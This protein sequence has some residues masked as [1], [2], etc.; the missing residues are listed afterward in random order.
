[1]KGL[2]VLAGIVS[3]CYSLGIVPEVGSDID[4]IGLVRD[5]DN[6][7]GSGVLIT[8]RCVLTARHVPG[9]RFHLPGGEV[10]TGVR[11]NHPR[12]D[13]AIINFDVDFPH[14]VEPLYENNLNRNVTLAGFGLTGRR[15]DDNSGFNLTANTFGTLRQGVNRLGRREDVTIQGM[16][17]LGLQFDLDSGRAQDPPARRDRLGDGDA[18]DG[19]AGITPGDSGGAA[20]IRQN[21]RWRLVGISSFQVDENNNYNPADPRNPTIAELNNLLDFG[22]T[23]WVVDIGGVLRVPD[24]VNPILD[25]YGAWIREN[26]AVPEPGSLAAL[27]LGLSALVARRQRRS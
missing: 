3:A 15:R 20:L 2:L 1:M 6:D 10:R 12:A 19:E 11:I 26:C 18:L 17:F 16:R 23:A 4:F 25:D 27:G 21:D 8:P 24:P 22:D 13:L 5:G 14:F 9:N 7:R